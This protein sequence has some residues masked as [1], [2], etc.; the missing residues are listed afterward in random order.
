MTIYEDRSFS[1]ITKQPPAAELIKQAAGIEKGS[2]EPNRNKVARVTQD[3]G[4]A[5][6][7]AEDG[8]P[9]RERR[10][11]GACR[12]SPARPGQHGRGGGGMSGAGKRYR[13]AAEPVD[14]DQHLH[15]PTEA[16]SSQVSSPRRS[17]TRPSRWPFAWASTRARPTRW[18]AARC[19]C[20]TA[21][22]SRCASRRSPP[23]TRRARP[24]E[25]GA[26]IV[27]G[28][29]LVDEV[30]KGQHRLRRRGRHAGHD[31]AR[32]ARPVACS[33]PA[34]SCRTRRPAR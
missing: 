30:M 5:D 16:I 25:A 27:G 33:G 14:R 20:H 4:P 19:R 6:R 28:E 10:R 18:S 17:S 8:R 32:S 24:T 15:C 1:F 22:A 23:A 3:A 11:H 7:R 12:S 9:Q 34:V 31:V 2:G 29:E 21:R 26:D 13:A